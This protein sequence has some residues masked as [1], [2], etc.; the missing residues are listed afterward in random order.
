M[1]N[2]DGGTA[3]P[4]ALQ[5]ASDGRS[6][7]YYEVTDGGMS[8]RDYFAAE[9]MPLAQELMMAEISVDSLAKEHAEDPAAYVAKMAYGYAD[10]MLAERAK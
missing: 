2:K 8:M 1:S 3:F 10:A 7:V 6:G 5:K 9:A 4:G